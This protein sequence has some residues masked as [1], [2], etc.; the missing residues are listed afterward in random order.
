MLN[1]PKYGGDDGI[2]KVKKKPN[3]L[4]WENGKETERCRVK[5]QCSLARRDRWN[6]LR[7]SNFLPCVRGHTLS[8]IEN[9]YPLVLQIPPNARRRGS[10]LFQKSR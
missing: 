9:I 10:I 7:E 3:R 6:T 2:F 1:V 4:E 8:I 5:K